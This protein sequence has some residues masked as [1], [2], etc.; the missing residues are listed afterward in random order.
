MIE[1]QLRKKNFDDIPNIDTANILN[2]LEKNSY[3]IYKNFLNFNE[4]NKIRKKGQ[5][6]VIN[7]HTIKNR[8]NLINSLVK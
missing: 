6:L 3:F 7:K 4:I 5:E 2:S 8:F 1:W